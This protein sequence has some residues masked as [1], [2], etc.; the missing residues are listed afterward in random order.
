MSPTRTLDRTDPPE[1]AENAIPYRFFWF[2]RGGLVSGSRE[3]CFG[4]SPPQAA[5]VARLFQ[6]LADGK[7]DVAEDELLKAG[8]A[9]SVSEL[10][11]GI[12]VK[13]L[14]EP[15]IRPG[16]MSPPLPGKHP[17]QDWLSLFI[18]G[19]QPKTWRLNVPKPAET[20]AAGAVPAATTTGGLPPDSPTG[21]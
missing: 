21:D 11:P 4:L 8:T 18:P 15:R 1:L 20:P 3:N 7:P 5:F 17:Q 9:K 10:F 14:N 6:G 16:M 2:D 12:D 13:S 19:D